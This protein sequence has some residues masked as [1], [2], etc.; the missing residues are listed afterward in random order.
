META[1]LAICWQTS[2]QAQSLQTY[3]PQIG[4]PTEV[5]QIGAEIGDWNISIENKLKQT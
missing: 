4:G 3:P 2:P 1:Y 5:T